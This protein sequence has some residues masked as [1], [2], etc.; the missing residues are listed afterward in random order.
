MKVTR[1]FTCAGKDPYENI[2]FVERSSEIRNPDG[3][4]VFSMDAV[5]VPETWSQVR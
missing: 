3:T 5:K 4:L 2:E 1:R